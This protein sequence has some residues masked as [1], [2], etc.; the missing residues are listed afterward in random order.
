MSRTWCEVTA[1]KTLATTGWYNSICVRELHPV[2]YGT[3]VKCTVVTSPEIRTFVITCVTTGG[4]NPT[5]TF[6][7]IGKPDGFASP[8]QDLEV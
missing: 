4:Q 7:E 8:H 3:P 1:N 6:S 5:G 2:A